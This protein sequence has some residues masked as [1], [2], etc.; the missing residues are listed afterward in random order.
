MDEDYGKALERLK[1][2]RLHYKIT[3]GDMGRMLKMSQSHYY[4]AESGDK[5]FG[6]YELRAMCSSDFD[7]YHIFTGKQSSGEV[8]FCVLFYEADYTQ[9]LT[10]MRVINVLAGIKQQNGA[11][12]QAWKRIY[13]DTRYIEHVV[14]SN[15]EV[16]NIFKITRIY[17]GKTQ[18][19]MASEIG[20]DV[21]KLRA[22]ESDES[23]PDSELIFKMYKIY[24]ISPAILLQDKKCIRNELCCLIDS[25]EGNIRGTLIA[26]INFILEKLQ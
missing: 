23:L 7:V 12:V 1:M 19:D 4:K 18:V 13:D 16:K 24:G 3:Q 22:L 2:A 5:R 17:H 9:L 20:V 21:K 25:A 6:Y 15:A 11:E 10:C 14:S 26:C 8:Y